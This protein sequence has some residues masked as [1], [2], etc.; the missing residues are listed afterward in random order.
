M[1]DRRSH[2]CCSIL[3]AEQHAGVMGGGGEGFVETGN[4]EKDEK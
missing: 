4:V 3:R 2:E 1:M